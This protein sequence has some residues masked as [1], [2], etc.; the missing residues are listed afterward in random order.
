MQLFKWQR[1]TVGV[2]HYIMTVLRLLVPLM[3]LLI[4]RQP[5]LCQPWRLE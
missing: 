3:G 2:A 5:H 4:M 1:D